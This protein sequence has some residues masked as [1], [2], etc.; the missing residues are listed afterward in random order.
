MALIV[1]INGITNCGNDYS[2]LITICC[3]ILYRNQNLSI[4]HVYITLEK[5]NTTHKKQDNMSFKFG[6]NHEMYI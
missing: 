5:S 4:T 2:I 1:L 6:G 3:Y